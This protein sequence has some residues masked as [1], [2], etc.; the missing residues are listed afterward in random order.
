MSFRGLRNFIQEI[1]ETVSHEQEEEIVNAERQKIR[2]YFAGSNL[3]SY[4]SK[5]YSLK[6]MYMSIL[7]YKCDFGLVA[8]QQL[9][10]S[11]D[12]EEKL[13]GYLTLQQLIR[14]VPD[15]LKLVTNIVLNDIQSE[16]TFAQQLALDFVANDGNAEMAEVLA[17]PI[18][19]L[20]QIDPEKVSSVI[21]KKA[22]LALVRLFKMSPDSVS[23]SGGEEVL[24]KLMS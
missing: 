23:T 1:R 20:I 7:G 5:K 13:V 15:F 21:R 4:D 18:L 14:D 8:I 11:K 3:N 10:A 17:G 2:T 16:N 19:Q 24:M 12:K 9:M 6:M 22:L